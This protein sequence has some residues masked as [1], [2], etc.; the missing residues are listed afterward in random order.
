M[1]V[2][3]LVTMWRHSRMIALTA[4]SAGLYAAVL[5]PFKPFP[6]IPGITEIRVAQVL[7]PVLSL[8]FG[9]AAAWGT[10][11]GNLIGDMVGG[12]FGPG[13]LFG[14]VGNFF[15]GLIPWA[16]WGWLGPLSSRE[17]P[18]MRNPRQVVE[19]IVLTLISAI[20]CAT[21][22]AWGLEVLRLL[23]F[24]V[25]GNVITLNNFLFPAVLGPVL[26]RFLYERVKRWGLLWTDVLPE[27]DLSRGRGF[28]GAALTVVG[29]LGAFVVGNAVSLG[30]LDV[31]AFG[32]GAASAGDPRLVGNPLLL[33]GCAPFLVLLALLPLAGRPWRPPAGR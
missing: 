28:L 9:P 30:V 19:F 13:S 21:V 3:E 8:L 1:A 32:A 22:I 6:L 11:V 7:P 33:W 10:A 15:L 31:P 16:L 17:E 5:I 18:T 29:A 25:L 2:R 20:A 4:L 12:T 26:L 27:E 23:P 14:F 24:A